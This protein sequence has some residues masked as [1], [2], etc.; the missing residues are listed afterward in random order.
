MELKKYLK[1]L[2]RTKEFVDYR[3]LSTVIAAMDSMA[4]R[5]AIQFARINRKLGI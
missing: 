1:L 3:E 5:K 4:T 2:F